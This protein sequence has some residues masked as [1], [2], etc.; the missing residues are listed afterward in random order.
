MSSRTRKRKF[1]VPETLVVTTQLSG[2]LKELNWRPALEVWSEH[3]WALIDWCTDN[4]FVQVRLDKW[5]DWGSN[6]WPM[7]HDRTFL[8]TE[9]Q[10]LNVV[11]D[12]RKWLFRLLVLGSSSILCSVLAGYC[13]TLHYPCLNQMGRYLVEYKYAL[14]GQGNW[15]V[16]SMWPSAWDAALKRS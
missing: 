5:P 1:H 6:P 14:M 12:A 8:T 16:V 3:E 11:R 7:D 13:S 9:I 10:W 15:I 2:T 4:V